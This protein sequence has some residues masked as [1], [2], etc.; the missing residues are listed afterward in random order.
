M[1]ADKFDA[2]LKKLDISTKDMAEFINVDRS[3]VI[4]VRN[5][6]RVLRRGGHASVRMINGLYEYCVY[7]KKLGQLKKIIGCGE[8]NAAVVIDALTRYLYGGSG[9]MSEKPAK[10]TDTK[11]K[12]DEYF[13]YRLKAVMELTDL[14][15]IRLSRLIN[16][17]PS[18]ISR[19][20]GGMSIPRDSK[21][22]EHLC[23]TL[24]KRVCMGSG[25]DELARIL[26]LPAEELEVEEHGVKCLKKWLFGRQPGN[27]AI[28][29]SLL[30]GI[31]NMSPADKMTALP[32]EEAA[33]RID[34]NDKAEVY[35]GIDGM[36]R[37]VIRLL[38]NAVENRYR[39]LFLYS[40]QSMEWL[41]GDR[42]YLI[43]WFSLMS[44]ALKRGTRIKIIHN[45]D[46]GTAEMTGAIKN[47]LPL[48]MTGNINSYYSTRLNGSR[49]SNTLFLAP[50]HACIYNNHVSGFEE[51]ARY[52]YYTSAEDLE[53]CGEMFDMLMKNCRELIKIELPHRMKKMNSSIIETNG[54]NVI[55]N[56][57]SLATMPD[58][59]ADRFAENMSDANRMEFYSE[60]DI[61]KR[62]YAANLKSG[63]VCEFIPLP[64]ENSLRG[65]R[66][67]A[68]S[69]ISGLYYTPQLLAKHLEAIIR[70]ME[71]RENYNFIVLPNTLLSN[72]RLVIGEKNVIINHFSTPKAD[73]VMDHPLMRS[74]FAV[75]AEDLRQQYGMSK[76]ACIKRLR[77]YL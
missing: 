36:R 63:Y 6:S 65:G 4:R 21:M 72:S 33:N 17:D 26:S 71:Q 27:N 66:V 48:Y 40:D 28:V 8:D 76:N 12:K 39:E 61:Q 69:C 38:G 9:E 1:S 37:A 20:R 73:F 55:Q 31:D 57:L 22:Q 23:R 24:I 47:W 43:K 60:R 29:E 25:A 67:A 49:F 68:D 56:R 62:R 41:T 30:A 16:V 74:A 53:K 42:S 59:L 70:L 32:F 54:V 3:Y 10:N 5:G 44:E 19:W 14:S 35:T 77:R 2:L 75:Y 15:N 58:A 46:R 11:Q 18:L 13:S 64:D 50:G 45:I 7:T 34:V 51:L 52:S